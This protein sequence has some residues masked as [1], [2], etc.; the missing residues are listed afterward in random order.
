MSYNVR[1]TNTILREEKDGSV[2][3]RIKYVIKNILLYMPDTIGFQE[4]TISQDDYLYIHYYY[5][6]LLFYYCQFNI[7]NLNL[8]Y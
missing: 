4:V 7:V 1:Y 2:Q 5:F 6:H 3:T 8:V